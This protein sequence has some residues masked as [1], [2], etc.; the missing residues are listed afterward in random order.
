MLDLV[1]DNQQQTI[2]VP[3]D[4][5]LAKWAATALLASEPTQVSLLILDPVAAKEMNKTYRGK[6]YATNVLSFPMQ[7][8]DDMQAGLD[9]KLLGD[10]VI[11]AEVVE[12]EALQQ[13]KDS[14]AHWAHMLIHGMLHL[15]GFDHELD[16]E[17]EVMEKTEIKLLAELGF[18]N[19]YQ[20]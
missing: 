4:G 18:T 12:Q 14:Q 6:D 17:A 5:V 20:S 8:P 9:F 13:K 3:E 1:I 16:A 15:Q 7:I 10:L 11:C 2:I 19:P